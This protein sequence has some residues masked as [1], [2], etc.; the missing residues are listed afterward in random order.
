LCEHGIQRAFCVPCLGTQT[1]QKHGVQRSSRCRECK[2][3]S[4]D[5]LY[6]LSCSRLPGV[7]KVG[8]STNVRQRCAL[9]QRS[10]PFFLI[11][12]LVFAGEGFLE[13]AVHGHLAPERLKDCPGTEWFET[14]LAR[15]RE[16]IAFARAERDRWS[17]EKRDSIEK[18]NMTSK[19]QTVAEATADDWK[20]GE[21]VQGKGVQV[22]KLFRADGG[23]VRF[24]L[25]KSDAW[26][27]VV[28]FPPSVFQGT[29]EEQRKGIAFNLPPE[30]E[31]EL[32]GLEGK[33]RE[34]VAEKV[35]KG[36]LVFWMN[37]VKPADQYDAKLKAKINVSGARA[38]NIFDENGERTSFP[39]TWTAQDANAVVELRGVYRQK[40]A[41]GLLLEV[42]HLKLRESASGTHADDEA[43]PED[44]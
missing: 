43:W 38:A 32:E 28:P 15:V 12:V 44:F 4:D 27:V 14:S 17:G 7:F 1:C 33:A 26:P 18:A 8:R 39:K 34:L 36:A 6:V 24:I 19:I 30:L 3:A 21:F 9:L 31:K 5:D 20:L 40:A 41:I 37:C 22:A 11:P 2:G 16:A 35:G 13:R 29:G 42:T 25:G 23:P 10:Q